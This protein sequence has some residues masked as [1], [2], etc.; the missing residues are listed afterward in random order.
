MLLEEY[1]TWQNLCDDIKNKTG[2]N[3]FYGRCHPDHNGLTRGGKLPYSIS[4]YEFN[5]MR[6]FIVKHNLTRGFELATGTCI[7]TLSLGFGFAKTGGKLISI[8]SY[9]E[10]VTQCQPI[11]TTGK[12]YDQSQDYVLNSNLI[13]AYNLESVVQLIIGWSPHDCI[14]SIDKNYQSNLD[15]A[16]FDCPKSSEDFT[17]D[18]A[19]LKTRMNKE[20]FAIFVHDTHCFMEDFNRLGY[21]I[22]GIKPKQITEFQTPTG[23]INQVF[24][25]SVITNIE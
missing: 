19:Y 17:R 5:Y 16:F 10:E 8:D 4:E 14:E 24:P 20:K 6:D 9:E 11:G 13:K 3:Y 23:K 7:S 21:E 25:L 1:M 15:F 18:I 2:Q 12:T 22:F